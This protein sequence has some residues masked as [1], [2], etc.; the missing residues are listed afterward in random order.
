MFFSQSWPLPFWKHVAYIKKG[1]PTNEL[2]LQGL[3]VQLY[4]LSEFEKQLRNI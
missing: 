4:L 1:K 2:I 3:N